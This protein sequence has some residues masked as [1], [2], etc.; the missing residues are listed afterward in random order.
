MEAIAKA[1]LSNKSNAGCI[2]IADFKLSYRAII[3]KI[4]WYWH[5]NRHEDW[6]NRRPRQ[7]TMQLQAF[8]PH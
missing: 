1:I 4:A 6:W 3:T 8:D 2:T 7:K 5:K